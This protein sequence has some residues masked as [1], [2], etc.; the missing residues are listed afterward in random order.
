MPSSTSTRISARLKRV[1]NS[2][3]QTHLRTPALHWRSWLRAAVHDGGASCA[4]VVSSSTLPSSV[5]GQRTARRGGGQG[6]RRALP[7]CARRARINRPLM[8]PRGTL[9]CLRA[10]LSHAFACHSADDPPSSAQAG[11]SA[12]AEIELLHHT[13]RSPQLRILIT[14]ES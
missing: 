9:A 10:S 4:A 13:V 6:S 8:P 12:A 11:V 2:C 5:L 14:L 1:G 3:M 7:S